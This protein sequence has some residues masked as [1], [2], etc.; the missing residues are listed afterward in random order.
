[1]E[2]LRK[3]FNEHSD[4]I[5][6]TIS[7]R[8]TRIDNGDAILRLDAGVRSTDYQEFLA[9]AE[10]LNFGIIEAVESVG[11]RFTALGPKIKFDKK[12]NAATSG[13]AS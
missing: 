5:E 10:V 3:L 12:M 1:M 13:S 2:N 11:A 6:D 4:V 9:V 7:I 8:F